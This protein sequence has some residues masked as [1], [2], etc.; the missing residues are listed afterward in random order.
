MF[1]APCRGDGGICILGP[2]LHLLHPLSPF[3]D[4]DK[5]YNCTKHFVIFVD[6]TEELKG[7]GKGHTSGSCQLL[8]IC[9]SVLLFFPA[10]WSRCSG[11]SINTPVSLHL[12]AVPFPVF[13]EPAR[14]PRPLEPA[15]YPKHFPINLCLSLRCHTLGLGSQMPLPQSL[16]LPSD[17][18][19]ET[20][21]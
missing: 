2:G 14:V 10:F 17:L 18:M 19:G 9:L 13:L 6:I 1:S 5:K 4:F 21:G 8:P 15:M 7:H 11:P 3:T 20:P 12:V 16:Q